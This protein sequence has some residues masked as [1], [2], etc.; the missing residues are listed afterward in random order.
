M[1]PL[2]Y[3]EIIQQLDVIDGW[4]RTRGFMRNDRIRLH[5]RNVQILL[6]ALQAGRSSTSTPELLDATTGELLW[7]MVESTE[8]IEA[9][10]A[11]RDRN[12]EIPSS[13]LEMAL[14]GPADPYLEDA[15][16]SKGRNAMF[17]ITLAGRFASAG[18]DPVI[19]GEPDICFEFNSRN[20]LVQC[21]RVLSDSAVERRVNEARQL[22]RDLRKRLE[23]A[24]CG[25]VAISVSKLI[26]AGD[27]VLVVSNVDQIRS[28]LRFEA[29]RIF[30]AH[31]K[32]FQSVGHPRVA[33]AYLE[34]VTPAFVRDS[35][36][37][38]KAGYGALFHVQGKPDGALLR[39]LADLVRI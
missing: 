38:A 5:R 25:I 17:E 37:N 15:D 19:G 39:Q 9:T 8:F 28:Q 36:M 22:E 11:L 21:K 6:E 7:S 12:C 10:T 13:L 34:I 24:D 29:E 14:K 20:V 27:K 1:E 18:L 3:Q 4:L 30:Q 16:S 31:Q 33:G 23:P 35:D 32:S 2:K 26:N